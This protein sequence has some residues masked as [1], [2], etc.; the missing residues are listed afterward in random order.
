MYGVTGIPH[1]Q[2][3]GVEHVGGHSLQAFNNAYNN[4]VNQDSPFAISIEADT[5]D[6]EI[7]LMSDVLVTGNL[8][9]TDNYEIVFLLTYYYSDSYAC[10]V[11]RFADYELNLSDEG[12]SESF[13][14]TFSLEILWDIENVTAVAFIQKTN[15]STGSYPISQAVA[16]KFPFGLYANIDSAIQSG[17]ADLG[18][19]FFDHSYAPNG[20]N[21]WEWDFENDGIIDSYEPAPFH[22]YTEEGT[23]SISLTITSGEESITYIEEDFITVTDNESIAGEAAGFWRNEFSPYILTGDV[24]IPF[25]GELTI[26]PGVEVISEEG[27]IITVEGNLMANAY[28]QIENS[29]VFTSETSWGGIEFLNTQQDNVI[30]N[31]V[32]SKA[33]EAAINIENSKVAIYN[34][35]IIENETDSVSPI[36]IVD[37]DDVQIFRNMI[38]NNICANSAGAI[39]LNNSPIIITNNIITN[40]T[41]KYG[42]FNI[43]QLSN[44]MI[45]N[46]TIANNL[47]TNS[48]QFLFFI[49]GASPTI[50]NTIIIEDDASI[51]FS[52][53]G[54]LSVN[55]SCISEG[56]EGDGNIDEI[57]LFVNPTQGNGAEFLGYEANWTLQENSPCVDAGNPESTFNDIDGTINDIG[58]YGGSNPYG[59]FVNYLA[60]ENLTYQFGDEFNQINLSWDAPE[61]ETNPVGYQV[62]DGEEMF[63]EIENVTNY[64][65][66]E[67]ANG[68]HSYKIRANYGNGLVSEFSDLVEIWVTN[69]APINFTGTADGNNSIELNW[70]NPNIENPNLTGYNLYRNDE[71]IVTLT[72]DMNSYIDENLA[73]ENYTY[74]VTAIYYDIFESLESEYYQIDLSGNTDDE[75]IPAV[76]ELNGNYPNPFNPSTT[77]KFSLNQDTKVTLEIYNIKGQLVKTIINS[78]MQAGYHSVVWNGIDEN[79]KKT[80]SGFYFYRLK[81]GSYCCI[82]KMLQVK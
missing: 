59:S 53:G 70:E 11:Q 72:T 32:I 74:Y 69:E 71:I 22:L 50:E 38:S 37:S 4:Y 52:M 26:E 3:Q 9:P 65:I 56:Y 63:V 17:P 18:V 62:F 66:S 36:T 44:V 23:Y 19:Q 61:S 48:T 7:T 76:T 58:A 21:S 28:S 67:V 2:F 47:S 77:I 54:I 20:M 80:S 27:V 42:A 41:G 57:P 75:T 1:T 10:S 39:D 6:N 35:S 24:T 81:A 55:Y 34:N 51:F 45:N 15:G 60:P 30:A 33:T 25:G 40:N 79:D 46:N 8:D 14:Q 12:D 73:E 64:N 31:C 68:V 5:D 29:I 16:K 49:Y 43:K 78:E 13:E 82:N